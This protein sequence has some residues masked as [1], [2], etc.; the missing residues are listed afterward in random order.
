[1]IK[2]KIMATKWNTKCAETQVEIK[3]GTEGVYVP[4]MGG[5]S[6]GEFYSLESSTAKWLTAQTPEKPVTKAPVL[7]VTKATPVAPVLTVQAPVLT[8]TK[9]SP[10]V[11]KA[12]EAILALKASASKVSTAVMTEDHPPVLPPAPVNASPKTTETHYKN[13]T[14]VVTIVYRS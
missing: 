2:Y 13:G 10:V 11:T 5:Q 9:T 3:K 1:M 14:R 7:T 8:V 6:K 12:I 4:A